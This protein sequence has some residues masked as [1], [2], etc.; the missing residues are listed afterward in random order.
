[1][2]IPVPVII[3]GF[4]PE[5][6]FAG[7]KVGIGCFPLRAYIVPV[8][9]ETLELVSILIIFAYNIIEGYK[10]KGKDRLV[11]RKNDFTAFADMLFKRGMWCCYSNRLI[12]NLKFCKDYFRN[13]GIVLQAVGME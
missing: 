5:S 7:A 9:I 3:G 4:N 8:L 6:I 1:L 13:V 2:F 11:I 12:E 10:F